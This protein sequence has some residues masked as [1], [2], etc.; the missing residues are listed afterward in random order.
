MTEN[1]KRLF[2]EIENK[3]KFVFLLSKE[4][5]VRPISVRNNWF[6]NYYSIP[7]KHEK[8]VLVLLQR[9]IKLQN[10]INQSKLTLAS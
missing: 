4:F 10:S 2:N 8:R 5:K 9:A 6:S 7:E 3:Q 1:I